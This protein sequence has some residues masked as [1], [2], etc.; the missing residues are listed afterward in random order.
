MKNAQHLMVDIETLNTNVNSVILSIAAIP[1]TFEEGIIKDVEP[2]YQ[3]IDIQSC[4]DLGLEVNG[5]TLSWWLNQTDKAKSKLDNPKPTSIQTALGKFNFYIFTNFNVEDLRI[6]GNSARFDLG[7]LNNVY[8]KTST[9]PP[10]FF[11]NE[12]DVRTIS[13][14]NPEVKKRLKKEYEESGEV[15][16]DAL[17]D[18]RL[19]IDYCREIV[20]SL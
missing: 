14:L 13:A 9:T 15:L 5:D 7:I 1:F 16:H 2:F 3:N 12:R 17:T 10:W 11:R 18:C 6:W 19:Q 20:N 4:L 8:N